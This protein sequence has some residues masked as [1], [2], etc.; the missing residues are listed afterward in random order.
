MPVE[1]YVYWSWLRVVI[2]AKYWAE[3]ETA[4]NAIRNMAHDAANWR[5]LSEQGFYIV[6]IDTGASYTPAQAEE[7]FKPK[8]SKLIERTRSA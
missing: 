1:R 2:P 7:Y 8:A 6:Q 5:K 3:K 4:E